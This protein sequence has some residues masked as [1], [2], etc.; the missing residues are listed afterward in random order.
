MAFE[1]NEM[2]KQGQWGTIGVICVAV[3]GAFYYYVW[4]PR[5]EETVQLSE[6]IEQMQLD[7][8]RTLLIAGQLPELEAEL[9]VLEGRLA[10]L[11]NI[12]PDEQQ[13]D[14]LLR[15]LQQSAT[16]VNLE[17]RR[18]DQ[19]AVILHD[20]YAEVPI[21]LDLVGSYHDLALFFDRVSKFGPIVTVG[22]VSIRAL[23]AGGADTIQAQCTASTFYF[24]LEAD[25]A[26]PDAVA[27]T[28]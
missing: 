26:D 18:F 13:T 9:V 25:V 17:I 1:F 15:T 28:G 27:T 6:Q 22:E 11:S 7:N 24:L 8:A 2:S 4:A 10:T 16:D 5:A 12:L 21:Q 3:I 19:Q 23:Q 20:F 14:S